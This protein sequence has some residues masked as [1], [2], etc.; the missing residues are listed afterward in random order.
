MIDDQ[1]ALVTYSEVRGGKVIFGFSGKYSIKGKCTIE[2][3]NQLPL[4]N[5][6]YVEE[7]KANLISINQLCDEG[8]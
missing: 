8:G 2:S 6:Y 7:M 5:V 4:E 3:I 1:T